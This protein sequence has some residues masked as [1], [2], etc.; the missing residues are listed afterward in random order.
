[1]K[2]LYKYII[3]IVSSILFFIS[4]NMNDSGAKKMA[5][6]NTISVN[7]NFN[8][9]TSISNIVFTNNNL[10]TNDNSLTNADLFQNDNLLTNDNLITDDYQ[11]YYIEDIF[12]LNTSLSYV[13]NTNLYDANLMQSTNAIPNL[14]I[15]TY[16]NYKIVSENG[17]ELD[18]TT[19][20]VGDSLYL[21]IDIIAKN[22]DDE[23]KNIN[24]ASIINIPSSSSYNVSF[25]EG[26]LYNEETLPYKIIARTS[27]GEE[28]ITNKY[29]IKIDIIEKSDI[30]IYI[31]FDKYYSSYNFKKVIEVKDKEIP[32]LDITTSFIYKEY[33]GG[34]LSDVKK[35]NVGNSLYVYIKIIAKNKDINN[36][37]SYIPISISIPKSDI[38]KTEFIEGKLSNIK[39][40]SSCDAIIYISN[41][42]LYENVFVIK[43]DAIDKVNVPIQMLFSKD[44][45]EH[46]LKKTVQIEGKRI[47]KL[48]ITTSFLYKEAFGN[49]IM[50]VDKGTVGES[51]YFY[52]KI[53]AENKDANDDNLHIPVSI[54]IP[55]SSKYK[56]EFMEGKLNNIS[57]NYMYKVIADTYHTDELYE[58]IFVFKIDAVNEVSIPVEIVFPKEYSEFNIKKNIEISKKIVEVPDIKFNTSFFIGTDVENTSPLFGQ[59]FKVGDTVYLLIKIKAYNEDGEV[60]NANINIPMS[61]RYSS[62]FY[63]GNLQSAYKNNTPY[64]ISISSS[65]NGNNNEF[66]IR[67]TA[68]EDGK[69][70]ISVDFGSNYKSYNAVAEINFKKKKF[71]IF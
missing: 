68:K 3:L 21:Y 42:D 28:V 7:S 27:N 37:S 18:S 57:N 61:D 40:N 67:I 50:E 19:V 29:T 51:L 54:N 10:I 25:L 16:V 13:S 41:N 70:P 23:N 60:I 31:E 39:D 17:E 48:N 2:I 47:H 59:E 55:S 44:Y 26:H 35:G 14:D 8:T 62:Y 38:Y 4:C 56:V 34:Q 11:E 52:V 65:E 6:T 33:N 53:I 66:V 15:Q 9:N 5:A 12:A 1:M 49:Q 43:I 32:Q 24:I 36:S 64:K 30:Q 20:R 69:I 45:E 71:G 63:R 22:F 58:S 46:N